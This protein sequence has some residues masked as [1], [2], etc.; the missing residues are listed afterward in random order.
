MLDNAVQEHLRGERTNPVKVN[1]PSADFQ[2]P[3]PSYS[4]R[5]PEHATELVMAIRGLQYK[6]EADVDGVAQAKISSFLASHS[7][8]PSFSE[9]ASITDN[10]GFYNL[11]AFAYCQVPPTMMRG[12]KVPVSRHGGRLCN[13]RITTT[14]GSLKYFIPQ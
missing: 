3:Y 2:P 6:S 9:W 13:Q 11:T 10:K 4:A 5:F 8:A 14:G 1:L 12:P 7:H